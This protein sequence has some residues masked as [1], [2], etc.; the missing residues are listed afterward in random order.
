MSSNQYQ[1]IDYDILKKATYLL[2][3]KQGVAVHGIFFDEKF[4]SLNYNRRT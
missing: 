4:Y 3:I 1:I 2:K